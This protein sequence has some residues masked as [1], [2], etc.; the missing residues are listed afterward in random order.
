MTL[1]SRPPLHASLTAT[2]SALFALAAPCASAGEPT[3][4]ASSVGTDSPDTSSW[5]CAQCPFLHGYAAQ[6]EAGALYASGANASFGRYTGI[7][8]GGAYVDAGVAAQWRD[9]T[10]SYANV[11][12]ERLGL[13]SRDGTVAG[14]REGLYDLRLSYDG[15]PAH[16]YD[17]PDIDSNR[18]TVALLGRY[19]AGSGWTITGEFRRQEKDGSV[20][21][22]ASFLTQAVQLIQPIAYVT[23]SFEAG[24]AWQ[25]R[26]ASFRLTYTGSWFDDG[27]GALSFA[28][29]YAPIAP[30][31]GVGRLGTMP[32]NRLQELAA[33][34][35]VQL[36]WPATT[37]T[38]AASI[39]E[40]RQD[41][42][43]LPF[44]TLP[45]SAVPASGSL[46][47]EVRLSHYALG[48][49]SR[50]LPKLYVRGNAT[51]DGRDDKTAPI[52]VAYIVTDTFPGGTAVTP[53][54]SEDRV[55]LDG[56]ADYSAARWLRFGVGGKF[57]DNH[58]G[59]GQTLTN[60]QNA[61]SWGR[62]TVAPTAALTFTLKVGN[63][64]RKASSFNAA[65]LPAG[66]NPLV[67]A[68]NYAPRD[69]V[70]ST[71]TGSWAATPALTWTATGTLAKDDYRS[72]HLGLQGVH[73]QRVSSTLTWTPRDSLSAYLDAGYQRLFT[74][75]NGSS[76]TGTLAWLAAD[77]ERFWNAGVGGQWR[78]QAR[79][80]VTL[81]YLLAPSYGDNES[82]IGGLAQAFPQ[83]WSKLDSTRLGVAYG[84]TAA[85]QIRFRYVR[86]TYNSG[87]WAQDGVG[88]STIPNLSALGLASYRDNVNLFGL[89]VRYQFGSVAGD[90]EKSK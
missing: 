20:L 18:R 57:E 17:T 74:L 3:V 14:G 83:T 9:D 90:A 1:V 15:Q 46:D 49:A 29:P 32:D 16:L 76:G 67:R 60:L 26:R 13:A 55:R 8:R 77:R 53:R 64:L 75:Q 84:W 68:Y 78:P 39:G 65:A 33:A 69:R 2:L 63:G 79:W 43:F 31:S 87:D 44:S 42:S 10:G 81:D 27:N 40:L 61:E 5:T 66:E 6:T 88:P 47:G 86:E 48:L 59:P 12:L 22:G 71:I 80:T 82:T 72:P 85:L 35:S 56:G 89:T 4:A 45:G 7:D 50:P 11:E 41:D 36:P 25:G 52:A 24:A 51:Y 62:A 38:Y 28:D 23:N 37:L 70:F 73:E 54:Y 34:G 19:F 21:G 30:N 58:Y